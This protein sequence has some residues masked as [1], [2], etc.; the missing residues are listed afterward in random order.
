MSNF[1]KI[2]LVLGLVWGLGLPRYACAQSLNQLLVQ[3]GEAKTDLAKAPV[4]HQIGLTYQQQNTHKKAIEY[5]EEAYQIEKRKQLSTVNSLKSMGQSFMR[6]GNYPRAIQCFEEVLQAPQIKENNV[7]QL[8]VLNELSALHKLQQNYTK[9]IEYNQQILA[10]HKQDNNVPQIANTYNNLGFLYKKADNQQ[11]SFESYNQA[12]ATGQ[13]TNTTNPNTQA[14]TYINMGVAYTST[15]KYRQARTYYLKALKIREQQGNTAKIADTYN[16]LAVYYYLSNNNTKAISNAKKAIELARAVK[17]EEVMVSSYKLLSEIYQQ[18]KAFEESQQ[19]FKQHQ[20]LKNKLAQQQQEEQQKILQKQID[21]EKRESKLKG[22]IADKNQ[23]EAEL[24]QSELERKQQQQALKLKEQQLALLKRNQELQQTKFKNQQLEK[25]RVEQ[26][27]AL[28]EQKARTEQQKLVAER[29]KAVAEKQKQEAQKQKLVAAKEKAERLQQSKALESAQKEKKL[30]QEQL[31]QEKTLRKYGTILLILGVV[32]FGFVLFAFITSK[33]AQRK[34]KQQ[35]QEIQ[36][37]KEEIATQNEELQ[38][39]HEEIMSQ[40]NFIE[41]KNKEMSYANHKL[42]QSEHVLRKAYD[43][44]KISEESIKEKN[45]Q[46]SKSISTAQTIQHAILPYHKSVDAALGEYFI[47]YKPKDVVSGDF[48]W[49]KEVN[50]KVFVI[51]ADCTG[52]GVPGALMSMIGKA[53]IDKVILIKDEFDP[54]QILHKLHREITLALRQEE[55]GNNNGMDIAIV[56]MERLD[57]Q[58]TQITFSAAKNPMQYIEKGSNE[59]KVLKGD[60]RAIGGYQNEEIL[61]TNQQITLEKGSLFYIGSDGLCDQNNVRRRGFGNKRLTKVLTDNA[62]A[63]LAQQQTAL[64]NALTEHMKDTTQRD[65]IL[66]I[67]VKV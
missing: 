14:V 30:Q 52:H 42:R 29:Q 54:A 5:F 34:L 50:N 18:E 11:K 3:L 59:V 64:E 2:M 48:Y 37:Q 44:L 61:F 16:Y 19:Y 9:A 46:I 43:K 65:D 49:I 53:L 41:E 25:Q 67:G 4:L 24:K 7:R 32:L 58:Q 17:A 47:I 33:R 12:L 22:L 20:Q 51:A 60:R 21:V 1:K 36:Q 57:K 38:Q 15:G 62:S 6:L 39:N 35:N 56:C 40:Q 28:A 10:I 55:T 23:K 13:K 63:S 8:P 66:F 31:K 45:N 27:L 26:L